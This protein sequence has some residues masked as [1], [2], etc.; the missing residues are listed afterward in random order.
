[1]S[2]RHLRVLNLGEERGQRVF[3]GVDKGYTYRGEEEKRG[4]EGVGM[5]RRVAT[6]VH[7]GGMM[8]V[9]GRDAV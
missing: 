6:P 7:Q 2:A 4:R 3:S 9:R 5:G 8:V 1:M